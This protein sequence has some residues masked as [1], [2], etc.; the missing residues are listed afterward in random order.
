LGLES[1]RTR[2]YFRRTQVFHRA[3]SSQASSASNSFIS[4]GFADQLQILFC[5]S[6]PAITVV[7]N[8]ALSCIRN[9]NAARIP[10]MLLCTLSCLWICAYPAM[11]MLE[12]Y[13]HQSLTAHF[14]HAL[15]SCLL[16]V[17]RTVAAAAAAAAAGFANNVV[18]DN[19][20]DSARCSSAHSTCSMKMPWTEF[21]Q[22]NAAQMWRHV[23][24][25][26]GPGHMGNVNGVTKLP[27]IL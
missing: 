18:D 17:Q 20:D 13:D 25:K 4:A 22:R 21:F 26:Q 15:F 23:Y 8:S 10:V 14:R 16:L 19:D 5:F 3:F 2:H 24:L 12:Y 9:T 1:T 27:L 11:N 7:N 6:S